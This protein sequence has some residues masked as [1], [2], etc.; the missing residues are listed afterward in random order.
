MCAPPLA[1]C[2]QGRVPW[3]GH[4]I[5]RLYLGADVRHNKPPRSGQVLVAPLQHK[6]IHLLQ[7]SPTAHAKPERLMKDIIYT[8]TQDR[9]MQNLKG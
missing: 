3:I 6:A 4:G 8:Y 1:I 2:V 5:E 9:K 7:C